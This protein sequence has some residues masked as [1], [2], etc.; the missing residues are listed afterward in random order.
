MKVVSS[1]ACLNFIGFFNHLL[2]VAVMVTSRHNPLRN[3]LWR[4]VYFYY[5][6]L[7]VE[8]DHDS[9]LRL[10]KGK[11][12]P[13]LVRQFFITLSL[14]LPRKVTMDGGGSAPR[15]PASASPGSNTTP[16]SSQQFFRD[17]A[18]LTALIRRTREAIAGVTQNK[19][20][21]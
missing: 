16:S 19:T 11:T 5:Q 20:E 17:A 13:S 21:L 7:L 18:Q 2:Y 1:N 4:H 8:A 14:L 6:I 3:G 10:H 9:I 12:I 15:I